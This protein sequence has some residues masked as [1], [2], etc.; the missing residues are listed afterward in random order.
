MYIDKV[1]CP[2]C[3]ETF[4]VNVPEGKEVTKVYISYAIF[5]A[6]YNRPDAR[7]NCPRCTIE[8]CIRYG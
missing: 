4:Q 8:V 3:N 6:W 5:T 2:C 7:M 1:V